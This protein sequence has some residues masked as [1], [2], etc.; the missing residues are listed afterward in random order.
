MFQVF[1]K[2]LKKYRK[3]HHLEMSPKIWRVAEQVGY[4]E[5]GNTVDCGVHMQFH[6]Y[7][8]INK[9]LAMD[10]LKIFK[11]KREQ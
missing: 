5:Q 8:V 1:F 7:R 9:D 10:T 3:Y 11:R 2:F 4:K 6:I